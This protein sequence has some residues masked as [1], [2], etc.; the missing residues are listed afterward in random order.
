MKIRFTS[1]LHCEFYPWTRHDQHI[2]YAIP[3]LETDNKTTLILAGDICNY[4]HKQS[5]G[6]VLELL[7]PRFKDIIIIAGNHEWYRGHFKESQNIFIEYLKQ[8]P[9]IHFLDKSSII[10]DD[11]VFIGAT[12]WTNYNTNDPMA[13]LASSQ[14]MN[15]YYQIRDKRGSPTTPD[16]F[17]NEHKLDIKYI[18]SESRK[19]KTMKKVIIT[20]HGPSTLSVHE[21]YKTSGLSNF[22]FM[23]DLSKEMAKIDANLWIHGH[24]HESIN[25]VLGDTMVM[26]NPLGYPRQDGTFENVTYKPTLTVEIVK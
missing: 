2:A 7:A 1:D 18:L 26:A 20:H 5:Y 10:I 24:T 22:S 21:K 4:S 14:F 11:I 19:Y 25:Y 6:K 13:K 17:Y 3:A 23:S 12:L 8:Y 15:D 16:L 9:N